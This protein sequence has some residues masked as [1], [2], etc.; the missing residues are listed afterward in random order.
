MLPIEDVFTIAGRNPVVTGKVIQGRAVA[1]DTLELFTSGRMV[2]VQCAGVES[3]M[4]LRDVAEPGENIGLHLSGIGG[5]EPARGDVL[6]APGSLSLCSEFAGTLELFPP[7]RGGT[8]AS[9]KTGD[10]IRLLV[11]IETRKGHITGRKFTVAP[12]T[13][14]QVTVALDTPRPLIPG[15]QLP[16]VL[17][18]E[19]VGICKVTEIESGRVSV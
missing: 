3:F 1:G 4:T 16:V 6:A 5:E 19:L 2:E 15:R 10:E 13:I 11:D 8:E 7:D 18:R 9:V 12:G 14:G 17:Q